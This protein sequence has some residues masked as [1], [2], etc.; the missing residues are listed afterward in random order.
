ME[1]TSIEIH[2]FEYR[3]PDVTSHGGHQVYSPGDSLA[4]P[5]YILSIHT[6]REITGHYRGFMYTPPALTQTKMAAREFLIGRDPLQRQDIWNE[7]WRAFRHTDQFGIG[8]IDIALWD[9]AGKYYD[10][11]IA[12][13]LGGYRTTVPAYASTY[14][15]DSEDDGLSTPDAYASFAE[16]CL[17]EGYSGFKIHPHGDP[18]FDKKICETVAEAVGDEMDLM[19]DPASEYTTYADALDVG[20]TLDEYGYFWYEDP[21]ADTGQ[22]ETMA[23]K[24]V[25]ELDTPILGLE[26]VRG[27]HHTRANHIVAGAVDLVRADAHLDGGITGA[28]KIA[29]V[30]DA[31]GLDVELHVGGPAHLHCMSAIRNTNYFERGLLHPEVAWMSD[32][33]FKSN[34]EEVH[35]GEVSIPTGHGLG[36]EIDWEFVNDRLTERTEIADTE[37]AGLS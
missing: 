10:A 3:L 21:H 9:L 32:Q 37:T 29:T 23:E 16:S 2:E 22:S 7:L 30:A 1:I 11:S 19:L 12:E 33:G 25:T 26:H 27:A 5:G 28:M 20:R 17:D 35:D 36:V 24:L 4:P 6:D 15:G 13:L 8:P 14:W 34:V 31:F 18:T